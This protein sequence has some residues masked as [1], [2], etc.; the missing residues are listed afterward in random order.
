MSWTR[1]RLFDF[2]KLQSAVLGVKLMM[3]CNDLRLASGGV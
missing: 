3:A 2:E 1:T